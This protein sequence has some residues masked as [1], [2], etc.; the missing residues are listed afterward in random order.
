MLIYE[1]IYQ[2]DGFHTVYDASIAA[3]YSGDKDMQ[4]IPTILY[5]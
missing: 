1:Y 3:A 5:V 2:N 4:L